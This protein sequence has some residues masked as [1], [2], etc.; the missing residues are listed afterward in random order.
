MLG[1]DA[2]TLW[3]DRGIFGRMIETFVYQELRRQAGWLEDV[4]SFSHFRDKE[5]IEV[6]IVLECR[7]RLAG[8]EVKSGAT[9]TSV[10]FAGLRKL[11]SDALINIALPGLDIA[12]PGRERRVTESWRQNRG[13][14]PAGVPVILTTMILSYPDLTPAHRRDPPISDSRL[15]PHES[16]LGK[17]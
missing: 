8:V 7:G 16:T 1:L 13:R 6:D 10:D 9:V 15:N 3:S 11:Q 4:I 5:G 2:D 14:I 12:D 17:K